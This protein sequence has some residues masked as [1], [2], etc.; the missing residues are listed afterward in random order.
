MLL[1]E[2]QVLCDEC[3]DL[4]MRKIFPPHFCVLNIQPDEV[5]LISGPIATYPINHALD[6]LNLT[7]AMPVLVGDVVG[8]S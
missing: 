6:Q 3:V 1:L 2:C 4:R 7:V 5:G 8:D